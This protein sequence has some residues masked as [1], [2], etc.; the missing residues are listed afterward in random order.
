M[1]PMIT[2]LCVAL[3]GPAYESDSQFASEAADGAYDLTRTIDLVRV[4]PE[5]ATRALIRAGSRV[6]STQTVRPNATG[7][8]GQAGAASR[9]VADRQKSPTVVRGGPSGR[10]ATGREVERRSS[11]AHGG[12]VANDAAGLINLIQTTVAP[13]TWEINGGRGSIV[14]FPNR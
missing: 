12:G 14:Y 5:A 11:P 9:R 1:A 2:L 3:A 8:R 6:P 13:D 4:A 7:R 10:Q